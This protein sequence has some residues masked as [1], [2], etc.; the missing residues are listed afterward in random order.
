MTA[1]IS[2]ILVNK[3]PRVKFDGLRVYAVIRGDFRA[4]QAGWGDGFAYTSQPIR[5]DDAAIC[6][7]LWHG[8]VSEFLLE[9][10]GQLWLV[11]FHHSVTNGHD[12]P[13]TGDAD[14]NRM[15]S[16]LSWRKQQ[17]N[18]GLTGDF[19]LVVKPDFY[20]ERTY[21]PFRD[22]CIVEERSEWFTEEPFEVRRQRRRSM[23]TD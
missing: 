17:V 19:W 5:Q 22:G 18:E 3:H 16:F 2:H 1:Q 14:A 15:L 11:A 6:S 13:D 21:I 12:P 9:E 23:D 10:S 8:F 20:G 4:S 7:A